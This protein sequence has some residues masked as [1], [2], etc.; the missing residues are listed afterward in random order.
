[1]ER[2]VDPKRYNHWKD[3]LRDDSPIHQIPAIFTNEV[4]WCLRAYYG[5]SIRALLSL[6]RQ[7]FYLWRGYKWNGFTIW[8]CDRF[9]WTKIYHYPET[10]EMMEHEE[11]H[12]RKCSGSPNCSDVTCIDRSIPKWFKKLM[13][14]DW[15]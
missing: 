5:G 14:R 12:G 7:D 10:E 8:L 6:A 3:R 4:W 15:D 1:M 13:G 9:G 2:P 11:R